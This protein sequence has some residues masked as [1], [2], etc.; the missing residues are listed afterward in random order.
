MSDESGYEPQGAL[1][2]AFDRLGI[3]NSCLLIVML[4]FILFAAAAYGSWFCSGKDSEYAECRVNCKE[5]YPG[6]RFGL[7]RGG[8]FIKCDKELEERR[9]H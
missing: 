4:P 1:E 8:C 7:E 9:K 2:K 3:F 5:R 6:R